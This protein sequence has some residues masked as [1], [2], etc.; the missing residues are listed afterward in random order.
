VQTEWPVRVA[1]DREEV[2]RAFHEWS[3]ETATVVARL[4]HP[5]A[6]MQLLV[7]FGEP[8]RGRAAVLEALDSDSA[9]IFRAHVEAFEWLDEQTSLTTAHARYP[10]RGRGFAEGRVFWLDEL[11]DGLIW[12]VRVYQQKDDAR[13]AFHSERR[14]M[15]EVGG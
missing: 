4:I 14:N 6:V 11:R 15:A 10:L 1:Q 2:L 8:I 12:R 13:N 9:A 5:Q 3:A 7:S